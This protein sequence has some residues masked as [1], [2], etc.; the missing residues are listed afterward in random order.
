[1]VYDHWTLQ[2]M[3]AAVEAIKYPALS[4]LKVYR[5]NNKKLVV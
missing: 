5:G 4:L 1:V 3:Q 2:E